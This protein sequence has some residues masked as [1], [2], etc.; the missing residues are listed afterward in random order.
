MTKFQLL[1]T[2]YFLF[3]YKIT[4][5]RDI[6]VMTPAHNRTG[7]G[8]DRIFGLLVNSIV[9]R[10]KIDVNSSL[11]NFR[12]E[13]KN[14]ILNALDHQKYPYVSLYKKMTEQGIDLKKKPLH[15]TYFN[16]HNYKDV[17]T[18]GRAALK[19]FVPLKN[20]EVLPLSVD[21]FDNGVGLTIRLL[22]KDGVFN[23]AELEALTQTYFEVLRNLLTNPVMKVKDLMTQAETV[24]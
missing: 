3:L 1:L 23:A 6:A 18:L 17:L 21:V 24:S 10:I 8:F 7:K 20:K 12:K 19:L 15:Q 11:V 4:G 22:S 5:N 13:S 16:F 2:A 14:A 9:I